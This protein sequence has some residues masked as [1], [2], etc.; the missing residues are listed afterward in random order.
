ML[1]GLSGVLAAALLIGAGT[2]LITPLGFAALAAATPPE[3]LGQTMGSAEL[4]REL[5]NAGG[6]LLVAGVA[7]LFTLTYGF[8]ALAVLLAI[9]P[10]V[11]VIAALIA[12]RR[13][14]PTP[15]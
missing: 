1:P 10:L 4:G 3:R 15:P 8:A 6:P 12:R 13:P 2:G 9:G 5:G 14:A 11:T 7:T